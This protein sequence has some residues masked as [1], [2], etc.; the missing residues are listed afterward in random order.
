M[1]A[2]EIADGSIDSGEIVNES[3][4]DIDLAA[5]SVRT[6]EILDGN[7]GNA[8]L[9]QQRGQRREDLQQLDHVLGHRRRGDQRRGVAQRD[10]ERPLLAGLPW[11]SAAPRSARCRRWPPTA[12]SR[13]A[14]SCTRCASRRP[15]QVEASICNFSGTSMTPISNLPAGILTFGSGR[16]REFGLG[17]TDPLRLFFSTSPD[18]PPGHR[19]PESI[20]IGGHRWL[21]GSV[22]ALTFANVCSFLALTLALGTGGAYAANTVFR[23][24]RQRVDI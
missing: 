8:D 6:S 24:H 9:A 11:A 1:N 17:A 4:F 14:C 12:R 23:R 7:V 2:T 19:S 22:R 16:S 18:P 15:G 5:G 21:A 3:L 10:P 13:T 20:P